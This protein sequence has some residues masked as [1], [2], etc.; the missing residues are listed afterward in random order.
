MRRLPPVTQ[1]YLSIDAADADTLK[2]IDR[3]LHGDFWSRYLQCIDVLREK[4][5][6]TV[7][8]LTLVDGFNMTQASGYARLIARGLPDLVEIKAVTYCGTSKASTLTMKNVPWHEQVIEFAQS[9]LAA[10]PQ[11]A[12]CSYAI[13]CEHRHSCCLLIAHTKW[14]RKGQ[15]KQR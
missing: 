1:L 8:R 13:A 3:P 12:G 7:Y 9:I 14:M 2:A 6:R 11:T 5:Q 15:M 4:Q 10:L